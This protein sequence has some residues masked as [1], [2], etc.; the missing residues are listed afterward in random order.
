MDPSPITAIVSPK[1][2]SHEP[3]KSLAVAKP[4]AAEIEVDECAAPK[5]SYSLS[6]LFVKPLK[7]PFFRRVRIRLRLP[8]K[9]L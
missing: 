9:I 1:P 7:P 5:G 4:K 2:A 3:P 6:D 8:V